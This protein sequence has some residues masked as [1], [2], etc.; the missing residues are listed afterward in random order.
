M[1]LVID[2]LGWLGA[3]AY[4]S[5]YALVSTKKLAGD[6]LPFQ[7]LNVLGGVLLVVNS[8]YY[9]AWPSVALNI[10]WIGIA[11][12]IIGQKTIRRDKA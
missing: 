10:V 11:I 1:K 3:A 2:I 12:F 8:A 7:G 4:L 9:L 5:A 6:S